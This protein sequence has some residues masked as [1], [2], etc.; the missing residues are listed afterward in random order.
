MTVSPNW[1]NR[2]TGP[3]EMGGGSVLNFTT[4]KTIVSTFHVVMGLNLHCKKFIV[5]LKF[6]INWDGVFLLADL[7]N[8]SN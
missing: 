2:R 3:L 5:R 1:G 6:K 4:L 7:G 8:L